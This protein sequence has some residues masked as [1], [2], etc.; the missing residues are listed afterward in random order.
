MLDVLLAAMALSVLWPFL[1][2]IAIA[3]RTTSKGPALFCQMREGHNG[4]SFAIYKFR[5]MYTEACDTSGVAQ[6]VA[7]DPRVTPLGGVL[8]RTNVD[9]LPQLFNVLRGEMSLVGPRPHPI[10]MQAA[11]QPYRDLVPYYDL[12][13]A[14]KPGLSGWAQVSG[15]RGPTR[16][17]VLARARI[18]HD[19]AYIQNF[20]VLLDLKIIM[21]TVFQEM[22]HGSG[23]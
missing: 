1:L 21:R 16:N 2:A 18:D 14:M 22:R 23:S 11:G 20:S 8:R 3:I 10:G 19:I 13:L 9:E 17:P 4:R 5:T 12:R 6:T 15:L 7:H